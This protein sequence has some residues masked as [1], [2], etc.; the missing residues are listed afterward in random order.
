MKKIFTF[1][2]AMAMT[3]TAMATDYTDQ[4]SISLNGGDPTTTS[5]TVSVT[6]QEGSEQLYTIV[7]KNFSFS[8]I[9]IGDVT[10]ADVKGLD[11]D[12]GGWT[13]F[14]E[15][16]K[17]ATI[18]NGSTIANLLGGKVT[19]TIKSGSCMN[20]EKLYLDLTL[21]VSLMG[22]TINVD[23]TFGTNPVTSKD[24]TDKLVVTVMGQ[25]LE[26]QEAT[27]NVAKDLSGMYTLTL[28]NFE[29]TGMM[30]VGT[31]EL[32]GVEGTE[33]DGVVTL[34]TDQ[35]VTIQNGDDASKTWA[36]AGQS[37]KVK[38]NGTMTDEKL[39]AT[40][41]I[42]YAMSESYSMDINVTFGDNTSSI[43]TPVATNNAT[44]AIYD[45][46]GRKLNGMT[47]GLNIMRKADGTS[48]KVMKK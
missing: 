27:I 28:K 38:L 37:V 7:L 25:S 1:L 32:T 46:A 34:T 19:V 4:L 2:A 15:T 11:I 40:L 41:V 29:I 48:V 20:G 45:A 14:E 36:M 23:A 5:T 21:P 8:G 3:L 42:T 47:R 12:T 16:T 18:T 9:T 13:V 17:E 24:Y 43:S 35:T 22:N 26:P 33:K 6:A 31:I 10:M 39:N 30:A 44:T